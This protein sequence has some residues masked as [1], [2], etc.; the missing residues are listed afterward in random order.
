MELINSDGKIVNIPDETGS[1]DNLHEMRVICAELSELFLKI[2]VASKEQ[3]WK[4]FEAEHDDQIVSFCL[5]KMVE[6]GKLFVKE[7]EKVQG[8][9][10]NRYYTSEHLYDQDYY[11]D[12]TQYHEKMRML[13]NNYYA[14]WVFLDFK[15]KFNAHDPIMFSDNAFTFL[16]LAFTVNDQVF[17]IMKIDKGSENNLTMLSVTERYETE[18]ERKNHYRIAMIDMKQQIPEIE[19]YNVKGIRFY[20]ILNKKNGSVHYIKNQNC[21][22]GDN[23]EK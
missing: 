9:L 21:G 6:E 16:C 20:A 13:E 12:S 22:K 17:E 14:F 10:D 2:D 1:D 11:K 4:Y 19:E 15:S 8:T 7:N 23:N 5:K 18:K 3:I